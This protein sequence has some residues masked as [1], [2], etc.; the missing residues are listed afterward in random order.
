MI[1]R[2]PRAWSIGRSQTKRP[3]RSFGAESEMALSPRFVSSGGQAGSS[4]LFHWP[5]ARYETKRPDFAASLGK[6]R[7]ERSRIRSAPE[8]TREFADRGKASRSR[9]KRSARPAFRPPGAIRHGVICQP[10]LGKS[11]SPISRSGCAILQPHLTERGHHPEHIS[12]RIGWESGP[13]RCRPQLTLP[14][15]F[16][17]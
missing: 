17:R 15:T 5:I 4:A 2:R 6:R 11:Q 10:G 12:R 9:E 3:R 1:R 13:S 16:D 8:R 7:A 14:S